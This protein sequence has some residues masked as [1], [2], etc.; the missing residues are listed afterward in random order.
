[1]NKI[2]DLNRPPNKLRKQEDVPK[3]NKKEEQAV[4]ENACSNREDRKFDDEDEIVLGMYHVLIT[5]I[6]SLCNFWQG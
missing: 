4:G 2:R 6:L 5:C 1:M 3:N